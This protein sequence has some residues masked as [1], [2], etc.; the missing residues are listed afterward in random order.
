MSYTLSEVIGYALREINVIAENQEPSAAQAKQ[1]LAKLSGMLGMWRDEKDIDIGW[2]K[3][4][5]PMERIP[6]PDYAFLAVYQN[7]AIVCAP[8]YGKSVGPELATMAQQN[9]SSLMRVELN[10]KID[11]VDMTH[12]PE[13]TGHFGSRYNIN[14]DE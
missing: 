7:L 5:Q 8:Q 9:L 14:T 13:G 4:D 11:N 1:S 10:N 6:V 2:F 12:L 3:T